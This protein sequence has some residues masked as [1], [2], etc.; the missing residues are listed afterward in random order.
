[1]YR[2][3]YIVIS[4]VLRYEVSQDWKIMFPTMLVWDPI[5]EGHFKFRGNL[6][7]VH[8]SQ[9]KLR[10]D[11]M[12]P[13]AKLE[14]LNSQNTRNLSRISFLKICQLKTRKNNLVSNFARC[15]ELQK[16]QDSLKGISLA[17]Y[18][19]CFDPFSPNWM[20]RM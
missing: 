18:K 13:I 5:T 11:D 2:Q 4:W 8:I 6:I 12:E 19:K 9:W 16:F 20:K 7:V 17:D 15:I 14:K 10:L 3:P 1:M